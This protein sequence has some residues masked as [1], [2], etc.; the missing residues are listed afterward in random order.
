MINAWEKNTPDKK[1]GGMTLEEFR[2]ATR[3]S[4]DVRAEQARLEWE[5]ER[6]KK[7]LGEEVESPRRQ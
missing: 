1:I 7:L 5:M 3:P 2:K 4:F 6:L